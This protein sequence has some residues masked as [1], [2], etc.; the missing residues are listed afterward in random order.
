MSSPTTE[1]TLFLAA[2]QRLEGESSCPLA[3]V[4]GDELLAAGDQPMIADEADHR[5]WRSLEERTREEITWSVRRSLIARG[6]LEVTCL[7]PLEMTVSDDFCLLLEMRRSPDFVTVVG[8]VGHRSPLITIHGV[9]DAQEAIGLVEVRPDGLGIGEFMLA[10]ASVAATIVERGLGG[11]AAIGPVQADEGALPSGTVRRTETFRADL[12]APTARFEACRQGDTM[13]VRSAA[14][15]DNPVESS[16]DRLR[17]S[18]REAWT[19]PTRRA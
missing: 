8:E 7:D 14:D 6:L 5:W 12:D 3:T 19:R 2:R 15:V 10:D 13:S 11:P 17:H 4:S 18:V 1:P 9:W 16:Y